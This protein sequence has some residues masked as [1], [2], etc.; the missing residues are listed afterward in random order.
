MGR[1]YEVSEITAGFCVCDLTSCLF[2]HNAELLEKHKVLSVTVFIA[3]M[4]YRI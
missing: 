1:T 4:A 3:C 2:L